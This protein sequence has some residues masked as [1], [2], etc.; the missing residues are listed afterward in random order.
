MKHRAVGN[1]CCNYARLM[2][3]NESERRVTF[4]RYNIEI[5]RSIMENDLIKIIIYYGE[6]IL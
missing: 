5:P 4:H 2:N 3:K 6:S 1:N